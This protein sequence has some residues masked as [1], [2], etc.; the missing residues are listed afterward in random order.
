MAKVKTSDLLKTI[1]QRC[2]FTFDGMESLSI[3]ANDLEAKVDDIKET[4][5]SMRANMADTVKQAVA[6]QMNDIKQLV[7]DQF[8]DILKGAQ[9]SVKTFKQDID[10]IIP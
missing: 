3:A 5:N 9:V 6:E 1:I 2:Q 10:N 7:R 8:K 4:M